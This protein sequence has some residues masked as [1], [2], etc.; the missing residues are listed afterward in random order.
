MYLNTKMLKLKI[1]SLD[2]V[3]FNV[4]D[5]ER[6]V[7]FYAGVL[8]LQAERL[9]EYRAGRAP[10][11]SIRIN[12]ETIVDFFPPEYH[13]V[14]PG[15]NNVNHIALTLKNAPH[16]IEAFLRERD[17]AVVREMTGNFGAKGDGAHAFQV[18]DP[19]GNTIELHSYAR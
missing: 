2:H 12:R 9:D 11:P 16:E 7:A 19:D 8:G 13:G 3:V 6:S 18:L 17:V 5:P 4:A 1:D 14:E 10:F 15:G